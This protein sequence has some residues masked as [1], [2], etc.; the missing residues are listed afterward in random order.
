V[1]WG[2]GQIASPGGMKVDPVGYEVV[3]NGAANSHQQEAVLLQQR[4]QIGMAE[5][6][7]H[8]PCYGLMAGS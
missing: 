4:R 6:T 1:V 8:K 5:L 7:F 2:G 3:L